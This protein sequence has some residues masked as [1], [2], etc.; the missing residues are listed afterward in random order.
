MHNAE[1][2]N[3]LWKKFNN[4]GNS[5]RDAE[6]YNEPLLYNNNNYLNLLIN[7]KI[8]QTIEVVHVGYLINIVYTYDD[9]S[10]TIPNINIS[11]YLNYDNKTISIGD[12]NNGLIRLFYDNHINA[13]SIMNLN[14]LNP[15]YTHLEFVYRLELSR[16]SQ[17]NT[18]VWWSTK[19]FGVLLN[20]FYSRDNNNINLLENT[21]PR[22]YDTDPSR[23][24]YKFILEYYADTSANFHSIDFSASKFTNISFY[25][26][27]QY[28]YIDVNTG[29]IIFDIS[30]D[31][32]VENINDTWD[33]SNGSPPFFSF[34]KYNGDF[35]FNNVTFDG[36]LEISGSLNLNGKTVSSSGN[37]NVKNTDINIGDYDVNL[38]FR[39]GYNRPPIYSQFEY[40]NDNSGTLNYAIITHDFQPFYN[41]D[42]NN[43]FK[44][45]YTDSSL[46]LLP[47]FFFDLLDS[48]FVD[49]ERFSDFLK[50]YY[51][52]NPKRNP[53]IWTDVQLSYIFNLHRHR[54]YMTIFI[55]DN[56]TN[57]KAIGNLDYD[58]TNENTINTKNNYFYDIITIN[59]ENMP[60]NTDQEIKDVLNDI[61]TMSIFLYDSSFVDLSA[62]VS[63]LKASSSSSFINIKTII[64][65]IEPS[66]KSIFLASLIMNN[67]DISNQ[68][69]NT[70]NQYNNRP[71]MLNLPSDIYFSDN[72]GIII[73]LELR[74][75]SQ[76]TDKNNL[77]YGIY[78]YDSSGNNKLINFNII[79][80]FHNFNNSIYS[81]NIHIF[82]SE[83]NHYWYNETENHIENTIGIDFRLF[84]GGSDN[85]N[86]GKNHIELRRF[87]ISFQTIL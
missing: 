5:I 51:K 39:Y 62:N 16:L 38:I 70:Y 19:P 78:V 37:I 76:L 40:N 47:M 60:P 74:S 25:S 73:N 21:I 65:S 80:Q 81:N 34:I 82:F 56:I 59:K 15:N 18:N 61:N 23:N 57:I 63:L 45:N 46:S 68:I 32:N 9:I 67:I 55:N 86:M 42:I 13:G 4:L 72:G 30:S 6:I 58:L 22:N 66:L 49:H 10:Y 3:I 28:W 83:L 29:Y 71:I 7:K 12:K 11:N 35:G 85:N 75:L 24:T 1:Y 77:I 52:R 64:N 84:I 17:A 36:N 43:F 53:N 50:N 69:I 54:H 33:T 14:C 20:R 2:I 48:S 87:T 8:N 41:A 27:P 44:N 31:S 26:S 79:N